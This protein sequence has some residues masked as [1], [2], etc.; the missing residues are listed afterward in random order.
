MTARAV[1]GLPTVYENFGVLARARRPG[2]QECTQ[3]GRKGFP[4][5]VQWWFARAAR[6]SIAAALVLASGP[7]AAAQSSRD[8]V[9]IA[10]SSL[11][12]RRPRVRGGCRAS[13]AGW[14]APLAQ[15][16]IY[17]TQVTQIVRAVGALAN[18]TAARPIAGQST[19]RERSQ[20]E[21]PRPLDHPSTPSCSPVF[22]PK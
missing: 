18:V 8:R 1:A 12:Q 3:I 11:L 19:C 9:A 4:M 17:F 16:A 15:L 22:P 7:I 13:A 5:R 14:R 2:P 6:I 10:P 21:R 20:R